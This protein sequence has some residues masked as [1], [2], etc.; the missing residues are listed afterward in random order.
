MN[1]LAHLFLSGDSEHLL[2]G[3]FIADHIKGNKISRYSEEVK[4]GIELHR[5]ID[6]YTD[7]H[8]VFIETRARLH[9]NQHKYAGVVAD[10]LYDHFLSIHWKKFSKLELPNYVSYCYGMLL[11]NYTMLP[12]KTKKIL[13]FIIMQN[14][15]VN[16]QSFEGLNRSFEMMARRVKYKSNIATAVQDLKTDYKA[17]NDEFLAFFPDIQKFVIETIPNLTGNI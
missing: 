7:H 5:H 9:L 12:A 8:P 10:I 17:Y 14:W 3:G 6:Y 16:Y 13:P 2:L 1:Y 15:L 11:R 4:K